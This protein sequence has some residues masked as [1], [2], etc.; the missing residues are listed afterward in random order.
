M[1]RLF[2]ALWILAS[3]APAQTGAA[4]DTAQLIRHAARADERD[5]VLANGRTQT[6]GGSCR[7]VTLDVEGPPM[8]FGS[9]RF[10]ENRLVEGLWLQRL[11]ATGCGATG[12]LS[13][14]TVAAAGQ[15]IRRIALLPGDTFADPVLQ[16][17]GVRHADLVAAAANRGCERRQVVNTRFAGSQPDLEAMQADLRATGRMTRPWIEAW[18]LSACGQPVMV[19][20][21]FIPNQSGTAIAAALLEQPPP[22]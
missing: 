13:V 15:P 16:R 14:L 9:L 20:M 1:V 17:D 3:C 7:A 6:A 21:Q 4:P 5:A 18:Q 19:R 22:R 11:R 8:A 2:V 10:E 12:R